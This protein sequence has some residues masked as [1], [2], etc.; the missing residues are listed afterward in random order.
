MDHEYLQQISCFQNSYTEL[1]AGPQEKLHNN[2]LGS[3]LFVRE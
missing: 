2:Q 1:K 3:D